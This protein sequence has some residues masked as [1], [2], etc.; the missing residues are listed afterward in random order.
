MMVL[1]LGKRRKVFKPYIWMATYLFLYVYAPRLISLNTIHLL[2]GIAIIGIIPILHDVKYVLEHSKALLFSVVFLYIGL[3]IVTIGEIY[4]GSSSEVYRFL[5]LTIE[6]PMCAV[7][8]V[9]VMK[10]YGITQEKIVSVVIL[11]ATIQAVIAVL[12]LTVPA[13]K[14][15]INQHNAQFWDER[16]IGWSTHRMYGFSDNLLHT[17][18]IVQAVIAVLILPRASKKRTSVLLVVLLLLSVVLNA[19]TGIVV[20]VLGASYFLIQKDENRSK[21]KFVLIG[22]TMGIIAGLIAL[23]LVAKY[24]PDM[25]TYFMEGF[26][27]IAD[28]AHGESKQGFFYEAQ[29]GFFKM[30]S[31]LKLIWG[32][33]IEVMVGTKY[34][35]G[36][37]SDVGFVNDMWCGG[38]IGTAAIIL[39]YLIQINALKKLHIENPKLMETAFLI[40]FIVGH[41]KGI[42]TA[43]NDYTALLLVLA[44]S[45]A[46]PEN[47]GE[48]IENEYA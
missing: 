26:S 33:G 40:A 43:Y 19:R 45:V 36:V 22:L 32:C 18:P 39:N 47:K 9:S 35:Y 2:F 48:K 8:I 6:V 1:K 20:F 37:S 41:M 42:L 7:Y 46:L 29:N 44:T 4:H 25:Y 24:S 12:M 15:L 31:G 13:F 38:I 5:L 14:M 17:T 23:S 27:E 21:W 10:H 3:M 34:K 11:N 16:Y 28:F 30:P